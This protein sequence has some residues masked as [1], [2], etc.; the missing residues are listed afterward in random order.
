MGIVLTNNAKFTPYTFDEMLKPLAMAT[1]EQRAIEEGISEL[2]SKADLMKMYANEEP[3]SKVANM[4]NTYAND[5]YKQAELLAK[6]GLNPTSRQNLLGLKRRYSSE[7]TPI[8]TAVTRRR[9]LA[10]EQRKAILA[11]PS[12]MYDKYFSKASL[13][14]I[15]DNPEIS[16]T[17]ISGNELYA[18][19]AAAA[20]ASSLRRLT[21]G[22]LQALGDQYWQLT[23]KQGYTAQEAA[24]WLA[25]KLDIPELSDA[26]KRI[27]AESGTNILGQV[28]EQRAENY[29]I[30]GIMSNLTYNETR[31]YKSNQDYEYTMKNWLEEEREKRAANRKAQDDLNNQLK[32]IIGDRLMSGAEGEVSEVI[33]RLEGLRK[34]DT[35]YSTTALD[36]LSIPYQKAK[37]QL[38]EFEAINPN[39]KDPY[40]KYTEELINWERRVKALE[41]SQ[42]IKPDPN[43]PAARQKLEQLKPKFGGDITKFSEY[44]RIRKEYDKVSDPYNKELEYLGKIEEKY[45][46]LGRDSYESMLI[47]MALED[48]QEKEI[49]NPLI[50]SYA[51]EADYNNVRTRLFNKVKSFTEGEYKGNIGLYKVTPEGKRSKVKLEDIDTIMNDSKNPLMVRVDTG[52]NPRLLFIHNNQSYEIEGSQI[53]NRIN[54]NLKAVNNYLRDFESVGNKENLIRTVYMT[55][56]MRE[57]LKSSNRIPN[58]KTFA[59]PNSDYRG[60]LIYDRKSN[61][62]VKVLLDNSNKIL[63]INSLKD[64]LSGGVIRDEYIKNMAGMALEEL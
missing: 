22:Q 49:N 14:D 33:K 31:D 39:L 47:G 11:N 2:G 3:N 51:K 17:P 38:D 62:W 24:D 20:K 9:Q 57:E 45:S 21:H 40:N 54:K 26:I 30:D 8:E 10:E 13:Q 63:T 34:T 18:K 25:G 50:L 61:N 19:G 64:E 6:Q 36:R 16:Y 60:A 4:Y 37:K 12:L 46:H 7:I 1:Q 15:M 44:D 29:I 56:A 52:K 27:K 5:L 55:D 23:K 59:I 43:Y 35:G 41:D 58:L 48:R 28:D 42:K 53:I 32:N